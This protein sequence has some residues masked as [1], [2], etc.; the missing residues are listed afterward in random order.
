MGER[1]RF[2]RVL[3]ARTGVGGGVFAGEE[4][5]E[6]EDD[7]EFARD[8]EGDWDSLGRLIAAAV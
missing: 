3:C 5:G 8:E 2:G 7:L 1:L 6:G 4:A